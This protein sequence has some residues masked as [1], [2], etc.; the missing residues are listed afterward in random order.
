MAAAALADKVAIVTGGAGGIGRGIVERFAAEGATVVI[1]D[2]DAA[3]GEAA[4]ADLGESVVFHQTDVGNPS[5][6]QRVVDTTVDEFGALHVMCNNAGISGG[7]HRFLDDT[8][9]DFDDLM[10]VNVLGVMVGCQRAALQ[11]AEQGGGSIVNI[12]SI[13]GINAGGGL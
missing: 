7:Q 4:A 10:R 12:A 13:G 1:A 3:R 11:M 2:V 9:D 6:L 5:D 8:M